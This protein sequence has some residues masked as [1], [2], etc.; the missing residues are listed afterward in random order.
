[1]LPIES[2]IT[3]DEEIQCLQEQ[4]FSADQIALILRLRDEYTSGLYKDEPPEQ[5]RLE[6]LRWLYTNGKIE[7]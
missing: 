5:R 4:G 7:G 6:F 2:V 1:M 3:R